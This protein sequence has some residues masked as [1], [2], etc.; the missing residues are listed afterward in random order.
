M[1][2]DCHYAPG[3]RLY[4]AEHVSYSGLDLRA[5]STMTHR[6]YYPLHY[7]QRERDLHLETL[8]EWLFPKISPLDI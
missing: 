8:S 6:L 1:Q 7:T 4:L 5:E 3:K 2:L